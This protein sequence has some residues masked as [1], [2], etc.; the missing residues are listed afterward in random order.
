MRAAEL[1]AL[2]EE[3]ADEEDETHGKAHKRLRELAAAWRGFPGQRRR[4]EPP[5]GVN[6]R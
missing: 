4:G 2:V 1:R 6:M 5:H 3:A